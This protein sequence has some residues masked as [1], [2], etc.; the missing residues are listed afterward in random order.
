MNLH[1][2]R[3]L[4][5]AVRQNFSLTEAA[6]ALHTSQPGVS[7]AIIELE[8]ELGIEIFI[9]HGKRIK[10]LTEPGRAVF[11]AAER[12]MQEI[13]NLKRVG[14]EFATR[15]SGTLIIAAT[16]TQA[17]YALPP[18]VAAFKQKYPGVRLSLLQGTPSQIA[19]LVL[20]DQADIAIATEAIA[21][22]KELVALPCYQWQHVAIVPEG[23]VLTQKP[24]T[25]EALAKYPLIT[26][27]SEFAGRSKINQ[28]FEKRGLTPDIVLEAIDADVI[29]TYV[30]LG[31]GV[32]II[33][34]VAYDAERDRG[35][36]AIPA[37]DLFGINI[38]KLA[39]KQGAFMRAYAYTFIELFA[40]MLTK[41][42]VDKALAGQ[43]DNYDL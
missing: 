5:E 24:L 22:Y 27:H 28:S 11:K 10:N 30:N 23:H 31:L 34:D 4:R 35:L 16:H 38:T 29:K 32:G 40:P 21:Q 37:G 42:L 43:P 7:K 6:R 19:D 18:A 3:F 12:I 41:A 36:T 25:L 8:E 14:Q 39:L 13:E 20:K 15:D 1:Q 33:A 2:L 17:R 9:R 26:Y